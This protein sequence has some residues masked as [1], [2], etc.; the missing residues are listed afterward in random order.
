MQLVLKRLIMNEQEFLRECLRFLTH[1]RVDYSGDTIRVDDGSLSVIMRHVDPDAYHKCFVGHSVY[2]VAGYVA[3][4]LG[5]RFE[6]RHSMY[7]QMDC[8]EEED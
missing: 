7:D 1:F 8:W 5:K 4:K 2:S 6:Y 3:E